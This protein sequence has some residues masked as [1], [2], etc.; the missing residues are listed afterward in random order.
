[1]L[2]CTDNLDDH[3]QSPRSGRFNETLSRRSHLLLRSCNTCSYCIAD[4]DRE[5]GRTGEGAWEFEMLSKRLCP[6]TGV[7]NFFFVGE[8]HFAVGSVV[9]AEGRGYLW[10][11]YTDPF[12][13]VG[14]ES[15]IALAEKRVA[16]LCRRA[17]SHPGPTAHP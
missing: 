6:H 7:V 14:A 12:A 5:L 10:R 9:K 3:R 8:P 17:A 13:A 11:C 15:D 2:Q 4:H 1:M 16:D